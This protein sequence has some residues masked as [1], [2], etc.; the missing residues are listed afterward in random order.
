[1]F[2]IKGLAL[3]GSFGDSIACRPNLWP[4]IQVSVDTI[5]LRAAKQMRLTRQKFVS[6]IA[7]V[8]AGSRKESLDMSNLDRIF[9]AAGRR[10]NAL[11]KIALFCGLRAFVGGIS[12][13]SMETRRSPGT[14]L[15]VRE[16]SGLQ[17][18]F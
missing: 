13:L 3:S 15:L 18:N 2:F 1:M 9:S 6:E 14:F 8:S 7:L 4:E 17:L 16:V 11:L 12:A 5:D 10:S